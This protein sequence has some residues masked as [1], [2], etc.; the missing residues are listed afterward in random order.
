MKYADWALK[1]YQSRFLCLRLSR[2]LLWPQEVQ[3]ET[4]SLCNAGCRFCA[5]GSSPRKGHRMPDE[6]IEKI[7]SDLKDIPRDLPFTLAPFRINEPLL[8]DRLFD[9]LGRINNELP[10]AWIRLSTNGALLDERKLLLLRNVRNVLHLRISVNEYRPAEYSEL[11]GLSFVVLLERLNRIHDWKRGGLLPF[12]V[13]MSRVGDG[14]VTDAGFGEWAEANYPL[15]HWC[16]NVPG[17][18]I[19]TLPKANPDVPQVG[20][21]HWFRISITSD[22]VATLCCMDESCA[23]PIG[24]VK[25]DHLLRIYNSPRYQDLRANHISR[26]ET[27]PC[28]VCSYVGL[29]MKQTGGATSAAMASASRNAA[30]QGRTNVVLDPGTETSEE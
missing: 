27:V 20:C 9:T 13:S 14:T 17:E 21:L 11:M 23:Y 28:R 30:R 26:A 18:W 8:D 24:D 29:T 5:A 12:P 2:Y 22:G 3:I 25:K 15:F 1:K 19:G 10:N 7:I 16:V 6:L 4:Q